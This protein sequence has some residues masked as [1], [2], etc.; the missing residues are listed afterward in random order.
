MVVRSFDNP[1]VSHINGHID[2]NR[3][4]ESIDLEL[5]FSDLSILERQLERLADGLKGARGSDR[6]NF[7]LKRGL[8][9]KVKLGL[10]AGTPIRDQ[11]LT[12]DEKKDLS[13]YQFLTDKPILLLLNVGENDLV[14][15]DALQLELNENFNRPKLS[16]AVIC[17]K[18]EE[19]LSQLG[20]TESVEFRVSMGGGEPALDK[21]IRESYDIL[22][23]VSFLTVGSDE[24]R[25]WPIPRA[26]IAS[27]AAGKVHSDIERGFIRA[28][29]ITYEAMMACGNMT[30]ARRQG[31][32]RQ[33]GKN[34]CIEDG[35]VVNFLFNV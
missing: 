30:E 23:L 16:G 33:E 25:A 20:D 28:E 10:E 22:G 34:Y 6:E 32:L 5:T 1:S 15:A 29:V 12:L 17:G 14:K 13:N 19:E 9:E 24:V 7:L 18:L 27:K 8:I 3:D 2:P 31:L 11:V 21:V 35:D 26:T 4:I